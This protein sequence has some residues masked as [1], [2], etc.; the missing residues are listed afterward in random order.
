[1][2]DSRT[3]FV[4]GLLPYSQ[5]NLAICITT[6]VCR[7]RNVSQIWDFS[8]LSDVGMVTLGPPLTTRSP[9]GGITIVGF[10]KRVLGSGCKLSSL[11]RK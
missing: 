8:K 7:E 9:N 5:E 11:G 4:L 1:M 6:V 3:R 2:E 10:S